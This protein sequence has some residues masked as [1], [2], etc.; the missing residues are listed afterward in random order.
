[1]FLAAFPFFHCSL[2]V[3][4]SKGGEEE[5]EGVPDIQ[6]DELIVDTNDPDVVIGEGCF[7]L[8]L[9]GRC[10]GMPVAIKVPKIDD[11]SKEDLEKF[12]EEVRM[13]AKLFHP[14]IALFMGACFTTEETKVVTELLDGD[15]EQLLKRN[16]ATSLY[17][18]MVWAKQAAEGMAWVHGAGVIHR[19]LKPSNLLY[20]KKENSVKICDFGFT[21]QQKD[22]SRSEVRGSPFWIAPEVLR[23]E[24]ATQK[25]DVYS[26]GIILHFFVTQQKKPFPGDWT[27][28]AEF[29]AAVMHD[30]L[31]PQLPEKKSLCPT[32]LRAL[33]TACWD[34]DPEKRPTFIAI[35]SEFNVNVLV[36][37]AIFDRK[38]RKFWK[39]CFVKG[40][41]GA[42]ELKDECTWP[43]FVKVFSEYFSAERHPYRPTDAA[44]KVL[45]EIFAVDEKVKLRHFGRMLGFFGPLEKGTWMQGVLQVFCEP[46][47][48]G[49][50]GREVA[51]QKLSSEPRGTFLIRYASEDSY[52]TI[53]YVA[54]NQAGKKEIFHT[55]ILHNYGS[56][57]F[58]L[59][60]V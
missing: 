51:C 48:W 31:R 5:M 35:L 28:V 19:D 23:E 44:Y 17:Q 20:S 59:P 24:G 2:C 14:R 40:E 49:D 29:F 3:D 32:S 42:E 38:A 4:S 60:T 39:L 13:M 30:G 55:R 22:V 50:T 11:V 7:G 15:V 33:C 57:H 26:Y 45:R 46:W 36:D 27:N 41:K 37:A 54:S 58:E 21:I 53:S 10:R 18:R 34:A 16:P 8:V 6:E 47:F 9:R 52:F 43:E 1:M 25:S 12:K 56:N